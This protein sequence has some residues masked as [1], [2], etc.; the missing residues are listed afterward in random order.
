MNAMT[1]GLFAGGFV[2]GSDYVEISG[3]H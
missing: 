1:A 3:H 2:S